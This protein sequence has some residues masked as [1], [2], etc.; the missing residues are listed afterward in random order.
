MTTSIQ[1]S[2]M[3]LD[4]SISVFTGR[5]SDKKT[6]D[7]VAAAKGAGNRQATSVQKHLFAGDKDLTDINTYANWCRVRVAQLTL[8]WT[9]TGTRLLPT[10][11]FFMVKAELDTMQAEFD[12]RVDVFV[13][14]YAQ[15]ISNAAFALGQLFDRNEYPTPDQV[16][17]KFAFRFHFSPV[18]S[19]GDFRVDIPAQAMDEVRAQ[20]MQQADE[21]IKQAVDS[22]WTRIYETAKTLQYKMTEPAQGSN[23]TRPRLHESTVEQANEL[24]DLLD[25]L[26]IFDDPDMRQM[27][28]ELREALQVGDIRSLREDVEVRAQVRSKMDSILSKFE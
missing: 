21:R 10:R 12:R 20:F 8:P 26:N 9:D 24:V 3:L 18:P 23:T 6:G 5:K 11:Q 14:G 22:V 7:E 17:G 19:S 16:R 27:Q 13:N 15:K 25:G 1:S 28:N 4:I 2:A